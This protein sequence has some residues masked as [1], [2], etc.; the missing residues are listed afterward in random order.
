MLKINDDGNLFYLYDIDPQSS[1]PLEH[2]F[3]QPLGIYCS[4]IEYL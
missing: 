1:L 2:C 4:N 3:N